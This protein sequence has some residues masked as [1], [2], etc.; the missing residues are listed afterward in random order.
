MLKELPSDVVVHI[1]SFL[2]PVDLHTV[3]QTSSDMRGIV[4]GVQVWS[5]LRKRLHF[6]AV[7]C[8]AWRRTSDFQVVIGKSCNMCRCRRRLTRLPLC[9][10]CLRCTQLLPPWQAARVSKNRVTL[11]QRH[12]HDEKMRLLIA[13][14]D[15]DYEY[16]RWLSRRIVRLYQQI[17]NHQD[18]LDHAQMSFNKCLEAMKRVP[19]RQFT[20]NV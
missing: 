6:P 4:E 3:S 7:R 18:D 15:M 5:D 2:S 14:Q 11:L 13:V 9:L 10:Q 1:F 17:S 19:L 20:G 16:E 8:K 12:M